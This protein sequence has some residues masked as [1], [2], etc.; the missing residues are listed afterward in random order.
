MKSLLEKLLSFT[1]IFVL[2]LGVSYSGIVAA[3]DTACGPMDLV[4]VVDDTGSMSGAIANIK[5]DLAAIIVD[6]NT[7]SGGDLHLALTSF[8]DTIQ[9]DADLVS[10][11]A[12]VT[13][14]IGAL[15][16][17]GGAGGP[18]ASDV[19]LDAVVNGTGYD[20]DGN[21]CGDTFNSAAW[22]PG[23]V[24]I[25]I[26]LTD[27]RPGGCD[28]TYTA[29]VD[30]VNAAA[31]A[32]DAS[33]ADIRISA[34]YNDTSPDPVVETVMNVYAATTGGKY[35]NTP[36]DGTGTADVISKIIADCGSSSNECPLSQGYWKNH[37]DAWPVASLEIGGIIY[38]ADEL[39]A[40]L[41][42]PPK[43]GNSNLI[44][45]HQLIATL[46]NFANGAEVDP[47]DDG[48]IPDVVMYSH[49]YLSGED[50]RVPDHQKVGFMTDLAD[51][52]D[53]YNNRLYTLD[54]DE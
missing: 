30:D 3:Q 1:T 15:V 36:S 22:R 39:L 42:T 5:T 14:A 43:R 24:K 33:A 35:I 45:G 12:V 26:M 49:I 11:E 28:D 51:I 4:F 13:A 41:Q 50:L 53:Y 38:T 8:K 19:A 6:A 17:T 32:G 44:L 16:A 18:E 21:T 37:V 7:A 54:C 9:T 46:L 47:T 10:S 23:A 40:I 25:A 2:A 27:N 20:G 31:V 48:L 34:I 52:L 29:G